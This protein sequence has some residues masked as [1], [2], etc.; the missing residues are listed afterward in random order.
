MIELFLLMFAD[1]IA[2]IAD[3]VKG[4]QKQF[5]TLQ[6]YCE[7]KKLKVNVNKTKVVVFKRGGQLSRRERWTYNGLLIEVI[8][9]YF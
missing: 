6:L 2:F 3:T 9:I 5:D 7:T 8:N 1:D 4:L